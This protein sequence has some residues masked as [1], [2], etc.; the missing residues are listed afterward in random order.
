MLSTPVQADRFPA[1]TIAAALPRADIFR[2]LVCRPTHTLG[3]TLLLTPLLREIQSVFP[4]AEVDIVTRTPLGPA[5]FGRF[6]NVRKVH[7]LPAHAFAKPLQFLKILW[8]LRSARYDLVIDPHPRSRTG[9]ALLGLSRGRYKLGFGGWKPA[10]LTHAVGSV[11]GVCHTGHQPLHLLRSAVGHAG[12]SSQPTLD[13]GLSADERAEGRAT[14]QRLV[15]PD[16]GRGPRRVIGV[17]ANATGPK[18]LEGA[19]WLRLLATLAARYPAHDIVEI[20]PAFGR[21]MLGSRY[22][23]FYSTDLRRLAGFLSQLSLFV[24][25]DC[26]V[27]HLA[28]AS[29]TPVTGIFSATDPA[30]W[31]PYGPHDSTI[32][33]RGLTPEQVAEQIVVPER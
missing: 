19:W 5:V 32:D 31:G 15:D 29:A 30:E 11:D 25:A 1:A 13:I 17:F 22:P 2:V 27:M 12:S 18:L 33:A 10:M 24:S 23:T 7:C 6:S 14:L 3:N 28:C 20:V 8:T 16:G 26:G 4:G 21:S 9:R